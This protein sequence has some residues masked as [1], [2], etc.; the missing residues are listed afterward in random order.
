MKPYDV[1]TLE[2]KAQTNSR[3]HARVWRNW[4]TR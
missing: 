4:Q 2:I 3:L 1:D